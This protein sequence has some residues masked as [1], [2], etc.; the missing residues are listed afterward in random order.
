MLRSRPRE[1]D[2]QLGP[3]QDNLM[4]EVFSLREWG[5]QAHV[6]RE[7]LERI[8]V[9]AVATYRHDQDDEE[10]DYLM[11]GTAQCRVAVLNL[12][13]INEQEGGG[14][15]QGLRVPEEIRDWLESPRVMVLSVGDLKHLQKMDFMSPISAHVDAAKLFRRFQKN[16][17]IQPVSPRSGLGDVNWLL[18]FAHSYHPR[19]CTEEEWRCLVGPHG[20]GGGWPQTRSRDF[21]LTEPRRGDLSIYGRFNLYFTTLAPHVFAEHVLYLSLLDGSLVDQEKGL[22]LRRLYPRY[23]A[24]WGKLRFKSADEQDQDAA[25]DIPIQMREFWEQLPMGS[26]PDEPVHSSSVSFME[27]TDANGSKG[28]ASAEPGPGVTSDA[29]GSNCAASAEPE[30]MSVL[31]S[32]AHARAAGCDEAWRRL[33]SAVKKF[34]QLM[35]KDKHNR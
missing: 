26:A 24:R 7:E 6:F 1:W 13:E 4:H 30:V 20:Y 10:L 12:K 19:A 35:V 8:P 31:V 2:D 29:N 18:T 9:I 23:L 11:L 17:V 15:P 27:S 14:L 25:E 34:D 3:V 33:V 5:R 21:P 32:D 16:H 28:P 22:P